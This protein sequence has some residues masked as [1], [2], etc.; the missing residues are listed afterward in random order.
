VA[1]SVA[2]NLHICGTVNNSQPVC[3]NA[4]V[5]RGINLG[6]PPNL[7]KNRR[8]DLL[9]FVRRLRLHSSDLLSRP[10]RAFLPQNLYR[11]TC[12]PDKRH[13]SSPLQV[14]NSYIDIYLYEIY[15][16]TFDIIF[17]IYIFIFIS[18]M[19]YNSAPLFYIIFDY[20]HSYLWKWF[21]FN[22][23]T[24]LNDMLAIH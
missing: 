13:R 3:R 14:K 15:I 2:H 19:Y 22:N 4:L 16:Y 18:F 21:D 24:F 7:K 5:C 12:K 17:T 8:N 23:I 1:H 10:D 20:I 11:W 9:H 6:V